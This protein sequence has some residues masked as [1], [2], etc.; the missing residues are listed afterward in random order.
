[1]SV[2]KADALVIARQEC[3]RRE[4]PWAEPVLVH[5]GIFNFTIR[6]NTNCRGG[7]ACFRVRKKDG[8]IVSADL[9]P[10]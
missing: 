1:M 7:N 2:T 10:K 8:A 9:A 4:W 5:W 6:T 3:A